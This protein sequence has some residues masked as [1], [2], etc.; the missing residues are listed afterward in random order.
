LGTI[1]IFDAQPQT[2]HQ[3]Q[4]RAVAQLRHSC[5]GPREGAHDL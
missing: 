1:E 3:A 5:L 2:L 4:A